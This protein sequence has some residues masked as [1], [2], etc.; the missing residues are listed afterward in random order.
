VFCLQ[1]SLSPQPFIYF[2]TYLSCLSFII[3]AGQGIFPLDAI[4]SLLDPLAYVL[5][6]IIEVHTLSYLNQQDQLQSI[7]VIH[8][9]SNLAML[10]WLQC[11]GMYLCMYQCLDQNSLLAN[12]IPLGASTN[13]YGSWSFLL[14]QILVI[15]IVYC[16]GFAI[17]PSEKRLH[18]ILRP[19]RAP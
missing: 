14:I 12:V 15:Q 2:S 9:S 1:F 4:L 10:W 5:L 16:H 11:I 8:S 3:L 19:R 6:P 18:R 7:P 13:K 17:Q